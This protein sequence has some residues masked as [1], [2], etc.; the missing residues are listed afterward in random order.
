MGAGFKPPFLQ[1]STGSKK[2]I[3]GKVCYSDV[4][5]CCYKVYS[6]EIELSAYLH[7]SFCSVN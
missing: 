6:A 1:R 7:H 5:E 3:L 4:I 2:L